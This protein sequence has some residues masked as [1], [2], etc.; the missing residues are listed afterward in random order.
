MQPVPPNK[1]KVIAP[2]IATLL[3]KILKSPSL[4]ISVVGLVCGILVGG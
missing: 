2:S 4:A 3:C 1:S